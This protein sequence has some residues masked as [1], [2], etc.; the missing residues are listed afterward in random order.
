MTDPVAA[1]LGIISL[2]SSIAGAQEAQ[3]AIPIQQQGAELQAHG[4]L[5]QAQGAALEAQAQ[6]NMHTYRAAVA[7]LNKQ[8]TDSNAAYATA[9]GDVKAQQRGMAAR[10]QLGLTTV[11]QAAS[12]LSVSGPSATRVRESEINL[13]DFDEATIRSDAA[14]QA[15]GYKIQ[16]LNYQAESDL[17]T[18]SAQNAIT[19]GQY[20]VAGYDT[21]AAGYKLQEEAIGISGQASLLGSAGSI[22]KSALGFY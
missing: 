13:A 20:R 5:V 19:A 7:Q 15:Y 11:A 22:S 4:A 12:G 1:T 17:E 6:A 3:K 8:F 21:E 10:E 14:R 18:A 2:G 16:G 9:V